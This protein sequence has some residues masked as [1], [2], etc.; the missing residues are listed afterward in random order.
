M[1]ASY[2]ADTVR[3][4]ARAWID[5]V[6]GSSG[7]AGGWRLE[8]IRL[9][10]RRKFDP[11]AAPPSHSPA[12]PVLSA[13]P[14]YP[15]PSDVPVS[16]EPVVPGEVTDVNG[17]PVSSGP[18]DPPQECPDAPLR[19]RRFVQGCPWPLVA[20]A[21]KYLHELAPYEGI[22]FNGVKLPGRYRPTVTAWTRDEGQRVA[23]QG[24]VTGTYTLVQ[25]L[26]E[27]TRCSDG[28]EE[29]TAASCMQDE[30]TKFVWDADSVDA[31]ELELDCADSQGVTKSLR[32][33]SR[34]EDGTFSYQLVTTRAK[35][36]AAGPYIVSCTKS[37][38]VEE[39]AWRN[40]YGCPGDF[41]MEPDG[42]CGGCTSREGLSQIPVQSCTEEGRGVRTQWEVR[43]N[44]DCTW[45]VV[46]RVRSPR[47][48]GLRSSWKEGTSC[49]ETDVDSYVNWTQADLAEEVTRRYGQLKPGEALQASIREDE[50]GTWSG[51][52]SVRKPPEKLDFSYTRAKGPC[53]ASYARSVRNDPDFEP[54]GVGRELDAF[55][56]KARAEHPDMFA[57]DGGERVGA[58]RT[59]Q[60]Q[61]NADCTWD[62]DLGV[63]PLPKPV[64]KSWLEGVG[65][66]VSETTSY[67][68]WPDL[69]DVPAPTASTRVSARLQMSEDCTWSG[70]VQ[71][72]HVPANV[73]DSWVDG[74]GCQLTAAAYY[75]RMSSRPEVPEPGPNLR[76]S[77]RLQ[78]ADDCTWS[79]TVETTG[80]PSRAEEWDEGTEC[81]PAHVKWYHRSPEMPEIPAA[82]GGT[83]VQANLQMADDCTWSGEVRVTEPQ[84][85]ESRRTETSGGLGAVETEYFWS[86]PGPPPESV[87]A[88]EGEVAEVVGVQ[89]NADCTWDWAVRRRKA[90]AC[91]ATARSVECDGTVVERTSYVGQ[92]GQDFAQVEASGAGESVESSVQCNEDGTFSGVVTR[93][94]R[95]S[96]EPIEVV[97]GKAGAPVRSTVLFGVPRERLILE[98]ERIAGFSVGVSITRN[99][100]CTYDE[101][102][103][104]TPLQGGNGSGFEIWG[105]NMSD[106]AV[107]R[108][109]PMSADDPTDS[110]ATYVVTVQMT[111]FVS[112]TATAIAGQ[113]AS[114]ASDGWAVD[115]S[116]FG[117]NGVTGEGRQVMVMQVKAVKS[118]CVTVEGD[119][120]EERD[121]AARREGLEQ[122]GSYKH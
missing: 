19:I 48:G 51:S 70:E 39:T 103:T 28:F 83:T 67:R 81:R 88:G 117:S 8:I 16:S 119:T 17:D 109:D 38:V 22:V 122:A 27:I 6:N 33:V 106:P 59:A 18:V 2:P 76:V 121:K 30:V 5:S 57:G 73:S 107:V 89:R 4:Q 92:P 56:A 120:E 40:L 9:R 3:A 49:Q 71:E 11:D 24:S 90:G 78:M 20:E 72:T 84:A 15:V 23:E 82:E 104:Y 47:D 36:T 96:V 77:A 26:I 13:P 114:W 65:C 102:V 108:V 45:D 79:G 97:E 66:A 32:A 53:S 42:G 85:P 58:R 111:G 69:P 105:P 100:D 95:G 14:P 60:V 37:E 31:S 116:H 75:H 50:D 87:P 62:V 41:R 44:Q 110:K 80:L 101:K 99:G 34:N 86:Q 91:E 113:T 68:A 94:V 98:P 115:Y 74:Q 29:A 12:E 46:R 21:I 61:R 52:V 63:E 54:D 112:N 55:E 7:I 35:S 10:S 118:V 1:S 25:D 64:R 93:R 43:Q